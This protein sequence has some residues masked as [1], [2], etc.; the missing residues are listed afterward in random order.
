MAKV[1]KLDANGFNS[2]HRLCYSNSKQPITVLCSKIQELIDNGIDINQQANC[3]NTA[4]SLACNKRDINRSVVR[5]LLKN[6]AN[7]LIANNKGETTI[8]ILTRLSN[9]DWRLAVTQDAKNILNYAK[10]KQYQSQDI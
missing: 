5:L 2:L 3:G 4:L 6:N 8:D 7:P 1:R 9:Q 10:I